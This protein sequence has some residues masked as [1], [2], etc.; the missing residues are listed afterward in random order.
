M[1]F[2]SDYTLVNEDYFDGV[3][4][5]SGHIR[6]IAH[7]V[8][9]ILEK[10]LFEIFFIEMW[11][12]LTDPFILLFFADP[13]SK[14]INVCIEMRNEYYN[15]LFGKYIAEQERQLIV[16]LITKLDYEF[17]K[18]NWVMIGLGVLTK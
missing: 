2:I 16:K 3:T 4:N 5:T 14:E 8:Y 17:E 9:Y 10:V 15:S 13:E 7:K 1:R 11:E 18:V 12:G 6:R